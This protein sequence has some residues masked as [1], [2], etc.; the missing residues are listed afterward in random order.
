MTISNL[1]LNVNSQPLPDVEVDNQNLGIL[2]PTGCDTELFDFTQ[3]KLAEVLPREDSN[4]QPY[5][6]RNPLVTKR[7]GLSH[8]QNKLVSGI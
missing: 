4:L 2:A 6:Y 8:H 1:T 7:S 5:S 3:D